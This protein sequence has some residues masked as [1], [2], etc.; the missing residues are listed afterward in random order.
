MR[1][2]L[3]PSR[4]RKSLATRLETNLPLSSVTVMGMITSLTGTRMTV[5]GRSDSCCV[6]GEACWCTA[7][8]G[9]AGRHR[10]RPPKTR[11]GN[12]RGASMEAF[13]LFYANLLLHRHHIDREPRVHGRQPFKYQHR[14]GRRMRPVEDLRPKLPHLVGDAVRQRVVVRE[15]HIA[16]PGARLF[17]RLLHTPESQA[18]ILLLVTE[19]DLG[20]GKHH[21]LRGHQ[22]DLRFARLQ[23]GALGVDEFERRPGVPAQAR[24]GLAG[25]HS[26]I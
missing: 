22:R 23:C 10:R 4:T 18:R 1:C 3:P 19:R 15:G 11:T 25:G 6:W 17:Q 9:M 5:R 7:C 12:T 21:L 8:W 24:H 20:T 2:G 26:L 16:V 14:P 13:V